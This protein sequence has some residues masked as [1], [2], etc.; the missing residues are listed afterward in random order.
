M[1]TKILVDCQ[2]CISVPLKE[3]CKQTDL[4]I[5]QYL[6]LDVCKQTFHM[7]RVRTFHNVKGVLMRNPQHIFI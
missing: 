1:K 7:S 2:I 3:V 6:P 5:C 4:K